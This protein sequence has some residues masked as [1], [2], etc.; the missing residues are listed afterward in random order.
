MKKYFIIGMALVASMTASADMKQDLKD[1]EKAF[2]SADNMA[3]FH[4]AEQETQAVISNPE[5]AGIFEFYMA[6][7]KKAWELYDNM[8]SKQSIGQAQ[9]PSEMG[10]ALNSGYN[11][12]VKALELGSYM[13]EKGKEK[14]PDEK[15]IVNEIAGS[16]NHFNNVGSF[17]WE[18]KDFKGAYD[19]WSKYVDIMTDARFAS[20]IKPAPAD[21]T[22][23]YGHYLKALAAWQAD[24][25]PEAL[26]AFQASIDGGYENADVYNYALQV[27]NQSQ[28]QEK[29]F[30]Y[31]QKGL[32]KYGTENPNFLLLTLNGYIEQKKFEEARLL[33]DEAI[34]KDPNN[35]IFY[36]SRGV[37]EDNL[38]NTDAAIDAMKKAI[39][40]DADYAIAY[41]QYG[42]LLAEKYDALDAKASNDMSTYNSIKTTQLVPLLHEA[43]AAFE[44]AYAIDPDG[45]ADSIK[46]LKSIYYVLQDEE[47]LKRVEQLY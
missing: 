18:A 6:P 35:P 41:Y 47:N 27:A 32:E 34:A 13:D 4:K 20:N 16:Y 7:G 1:V 3:A 21:S 19:M 37:L 22:V 28:N 44:K 9:N 31:A 12:Y 30:Y 8:F 38:G 29:M 14:K 17:L 42:R 24:M 46:Y 26:D 15:K 2:K 5:N 23:A 10:D 43:A 11:Y 45:Q 36:F 33:L 40:I 25:L 39:E